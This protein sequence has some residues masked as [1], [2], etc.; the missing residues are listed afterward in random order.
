MN[1]LD[2]VLIGYFD[3]TT[4][5][6]LGRYF[7]REFT[8]AEKEQ[9]LEAD[10]FFSGC[11]SVIEEWEKHLQGKVFKEMERLISHQELAERGELTYENMEGKTIEQKRQETIEQ[12]EI[13]LKANDKFKHT[14][15][16]S[17]LTGGR[18]AYTMYYGEVLLIKSSITEAFE[19]ALK[20]NGLYEP[21]LVVEDENKT[22][23]V[24]D[25]RKPAAELLS[26]LITHE[27]SVHIS[28]K[29]KVKYKGI[30]GKRLKLLL[31]AFQDLGLIQ[32]EQIGQRFHTC[33]EN[34]FNWNVASYNA[35]NGYNYNESTD[36]VELTKMTEFLTLIIK[37]K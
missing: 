3:S 27:S 35:M 14:V 36:S 37:S 8:K 13:G 7:F 24:T 31:M 20:E 18:V 1:Y 29:I 26:D 11:L 9:S 4:R 28:E 5:K 30:R 22:S 6:F 25:E 34:E 33:C 21:P 23:L 16:L 10:E 15:N 2:I 19:K 32:K 17:S 12:C